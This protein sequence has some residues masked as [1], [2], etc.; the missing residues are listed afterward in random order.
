MI[1]H[2]LDEKLH[3]LEYEKKRISYKMDEALFYLLQKIQDVDKGPDPTSYLYSLQLPNLV[4]EDDQAHTSTNLFN[5]EV[6]QNGA[7]PS[8]H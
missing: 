2:T 7:K 6:D 5:V 1:D 3:H 8:M 4:K